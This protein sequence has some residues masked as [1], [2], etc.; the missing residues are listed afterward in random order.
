MISTFFVSLALASTAHAQPQPMPMETPA[1][2]IALITE[3]YAAEAAGIAA[4]DCAM[5]DVDCL[6]DEL[7]ER[8]RVDQWVRVQLRSMELCGEFAGTHSQQCRMQIMGTAAFE[9]DVPNLARLKEI[10]AVH[11]WPSPPLFANEAQRGAWY[12]AQHGQY[13]DE[14]GMTQWDADFAERILPDVMAAVEAEE[15]TAWAYGAMY[16]RIQLTRG[17]Q[18]RFGTQVRCSEG[19]ADFSNTVDYDRIDEFRAEIGM[20]AFSQEAYDAYCS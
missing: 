4:F 2:M 19:R 17:G 1:E 7:I 5:E 6:A 3:G 13:I 8:F 9:G 18:Q 12:I 14:T 15:L 16:D 20:D 11:G 10:M